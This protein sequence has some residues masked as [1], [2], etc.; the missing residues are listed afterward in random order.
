MPLL[1][2]DRHVRSLFDIAINA[3]NGSIVK[4]IMMFSRNMLSRAVALAEEHDLHPYLGN[5]Q[6]TGKIRC[7]HLN[8]EGSKIR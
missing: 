2:K 6:I 3:A 5:I 7:N 1:P 4:E 8:S